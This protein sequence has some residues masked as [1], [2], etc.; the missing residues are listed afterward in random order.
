MT[1]PDLWTALH[2][3]PDPE[4]GLDIVDL[5]LVYEAKF[6]PETAIARIVATFTSPA[7]PA[8]ELIADGIVRRL[9]AVPGVSDVELEITFEPRWTPARISEAGR[10]RLMR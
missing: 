8:G 2:D 3:V 7:C 1:C 6:D 9:S 4:T 5:G 10:A